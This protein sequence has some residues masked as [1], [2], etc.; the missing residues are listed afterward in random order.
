MLTESPAKASKSP[1]KDEAYVVSLCDEVLGLVGSR[2]HRFDFLRGDSRS[3]RR[4]VTLAVDV[5]Y[6]ELSLVIEYQGRQHTEAVRFFDKPDRIT[7]SGVHRGE[8]RKIYD[9]RRRDVLPKHGIRL[10][11]ISFQD[12]SCD[13]RGR[14][15]GH[16]EKDIEVIRR[17]LA[18]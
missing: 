12:L 16:R 7:A 17:A 1:V 9:Q 5:Y 11:E 13:S 6:P 15:L 8:Q 4:A 3:G 18:R 10:V 14:L 2:Q